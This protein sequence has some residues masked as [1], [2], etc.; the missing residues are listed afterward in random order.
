M[1]TYLIQLYLK[2]FVTCDLPRQENEW[3]LRENILFFTLCLQVFFFT[4]CPRNLDLFYKLSYCIKWVKTSWTYITWWQYDQ[5]GWEVHKYIFT[6][7]APQIESSR[8]NRGFKLFVNARWQL[9]IVLIYWVSQN[10]P[11]ICTASAYVYHKSILKQKQY[12]FAVKFWDTFLLHHFGVE[13]LK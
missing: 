12:R 8:Y 4:L 5:R 10:L 7:L 13:I 11:Q 2:Y 9:R 1:F 3:P 6:R